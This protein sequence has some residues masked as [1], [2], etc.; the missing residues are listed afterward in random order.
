M[1]ISV[2]TSDLADYVEGL[3]YNQI[4]LAL[5]GA[6]NTV[7]SA[8][9]SESEVLVEEVIRGDTLALLADNSDFPEFGLDY[10][11][12]YDSL[13]NKLAMDLTDD[14]DNPE[15]QVLYDEM[16]SASYVRLLN[17]LYSTDK[18]ILRLTLEFEYNGA[19][20]PPVQPMYYHQSPD[21]KAGVLDTNAVIDYLPNRIQ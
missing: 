18:G 13:V 7:V 15:V 5:E 10:D 9:V 2:H 6:I 21:L 8:A 3:N 20:F 14:R 4:L 19:E 1:S 17:H 11:D 16:V 12:Q